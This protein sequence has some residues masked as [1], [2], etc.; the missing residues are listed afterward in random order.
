[1][2]KSVEPFSILLS[3]PSSRVET[4]VTVA[5]VDMRTS[6]KAPRGPARGSCH[7]IAAADPRA[8]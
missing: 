1:V 7:V 8:A 5:G 2:N 3:A 4:G 6:K